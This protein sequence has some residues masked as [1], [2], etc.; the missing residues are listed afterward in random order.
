[1]SLPQHPTPAQN[2]NDTTNLSPNEVPRALMHAGVVAIIEGIIGSVLAIAAA[3][4]QALAGTDGSLLVSDPSR[5][6]MIGYGTAVFLL[7]VFGAVGVAGVY[8]RRGNRWGRGPVLMMQ[9]LL[10]MITIYMWKGGMP[11]LAII[12]GAVALY[13]LSRL[14]AKESVAWAARMY[15]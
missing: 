3:V 13:C 11:W 5:G 7:C 12:V 9:L 14:F 1:M 2:T 4:H 8:L 6:S 15:G 10:V